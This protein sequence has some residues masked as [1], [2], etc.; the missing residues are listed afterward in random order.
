[1]EA[2]PTVTGETDSQQ[3]SR[4]PT[5]S[6]QTDVIALIWR[7]L[8]HPG[9]LPATALVSLLFVL[10][11][12]LLPQLPEQFRDESA[13]TSRWILTTATEYGA[14]GP[15]MRGMGIFDALHSLLFRLSL[16]ILTLIFAL[17]LA[18]SLGASLAYHRIRRRLCHPARKIVA[19]LDVGDGYT[20]C[21]RRFA[22]SALPRDAQ[23]LATQ[24]IASRFDSTT[25]CELETRA[26]SESGSDRQDEGLLHEPLELR[27]LGVRNAG[28]FLLQPLLPLALFAALAIV[29]L[30]LLRGWEIESTTLAPGDFFRA[31]SRDLLISYH[32]PEA[33]SLGH[34]PALVTIQ[35]DR[36]AITATASSDF[37]ARTGASRLEGRQSIPGLLIRVTDGRK[38]LAEP[39]QI[40]R[41]ASVGVILPSPGSEESLLI[42]DM[43]M[44]LRIVRSTGDSV[45]FIVELYRGAELSPL[46]RIEVTGPTLTSAGIGSESFELEFLP[47]PGINVTV[48]HMPGQ[49]LLWIAALLSIAG[50]IGVLRPPAFA[51]AQIGPWPVM[52]SVVILQTRRRDDMETITAAVQSEQSSGAPDS[53]RTTNAESGDMMESQFTEHRN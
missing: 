2:P 9:L 34:D 26:E 48:R 28:S 29:W 17:H 32:V 3:S 10:A 30:F 15:L 51:V 18:D 19:P 42:P 43:A 44:G 16:A 6:R 25:C 38:L 33:T 46:D 37:R 45:A 14:A 24:V 35:L 8:L 4:T 23:A 53:E 21:R 39:G 13:A 47:V 31:P 52:R 41:A 7:F 50:F 12:L 49:W 20:V 22:V 11:A 5:R 1:M 40:D 27:I 36:R